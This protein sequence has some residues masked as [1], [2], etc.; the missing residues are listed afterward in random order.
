[1]VLITTLFVLEI[2]QNG[3]IVDLIAGV[4]VCRKLDVDEGFQLL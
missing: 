3:D 2:A 1:M 4:E